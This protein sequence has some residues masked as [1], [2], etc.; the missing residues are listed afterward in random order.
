MCG[1]QYTSL[2]HCMQTPA[3]GQEADKI[4]Y[5]IHTG[6]ILGGPEGKTIP[7]LVLHEHEESR[8]CVSILTHIS[9]NGHDVQKWC[10][11]NPLWITN[12]WENNKPRNYFQEKGTTCCVTR[13]LKEDSVQ[14]SH[15]FSFGAH[16]QLLLQKNSRTFSF[17]AGCTHYC[18]AQVHFICFNPHTFSQISLTMSD[19]EKNQNSTTNYLQKLSIQTYRMK[20]QQTWF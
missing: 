19:A 15:V 7:G 3:N 17:S 16:I 4:S 1:L 14:Q 2:A 18:R 13:G 5:H 20:L 12:Q 6:D 11:W 9:H 8:R 10:S